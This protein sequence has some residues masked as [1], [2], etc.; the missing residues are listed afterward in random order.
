M[1]ST[2]GLSTYA[3]TLSVQRAVVIIAVFAV[4]APFY[5][6]LGRHKL[7]LPIVGPE[8]IVISGFRTNRGQKSTDLVISDPED[9][10]SSILLELG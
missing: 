2:G 3:C 9:N 4:I 8:I 7:K 10:S 5:R 6:D 1:D